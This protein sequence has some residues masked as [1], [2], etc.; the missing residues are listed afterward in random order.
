MAV[1]GNL[2]ATDRPSPARWGLRSVR[3]R[4]SALPKKLMLSPAPR[5][6]GRLA[7]V[8]VWA[9]IVPSWLSGMPF[10]GQE[11]DA[12]AVWARPRGRP[13]WP[14][15][16]GQRGPSGGTGWQFYQKRQEESKAPLNAG[17]LLRVQ[18]A[19]ELMPLRPGW[20]KVPKPEHLDP[21]GRGP[22]WGAGSS[23]VW[24]DPLL[25]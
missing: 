12:R 1:G 16:A 3:S 22:G 21:R 17:C 9:G 13:V 11:L 19:S 10:L 20:G 4:A 8:G 15:T 7:V 25:G 14:G 23:R 2:Q 5:V 6:T 24:R 18:A